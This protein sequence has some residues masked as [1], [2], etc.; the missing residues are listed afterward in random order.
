MRTVLTR[1][2]TALRL[3]GTRSNRDAVGALVVLRAGGRLQVRQVDAASGYLSQST[4]TLHF[5]LGDASTIE[6]CE[7]RWPSGVVQKLDGARV[8]AVNAV[9]EPATK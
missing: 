2:W 4:K 8:D 5:G 9:T 7:I 3:T 6:S 1:R